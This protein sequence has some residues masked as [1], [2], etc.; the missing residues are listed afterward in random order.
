MRQSAL[1]KKLLL[2]FS[3]DLCKYLKIRFSYQFLEVKNILQ[4]IRSG[5]YVHFLI[6]D[7]MIQCWYPFMQFVKLQR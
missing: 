3:I 5:M 2:F 4:Y 7:M 6:Y 1:D